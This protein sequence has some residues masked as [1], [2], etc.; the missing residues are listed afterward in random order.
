MELNRLVYSDNSVLNKIPT[1]STKVVSNGKYVAKKAGLY[2]AFGTAD[3][4]G[5]VPAY[6]VNTNG[7]TIFKS[8]YTWGPGN[9]KYIAV[10]SWIGYLEVGQYISITGGN[11]GGSAYYLN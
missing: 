7:R 5:N 4:E 3:G 9:N 6:S 11:G 10:A 2:C 1:K 8:V